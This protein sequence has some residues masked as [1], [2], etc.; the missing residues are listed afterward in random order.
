MVVVLVVVAEGGVVVVV[1][2]EEV[3]VVVVVVVVVA[4]AVLAAVLVVV[5]T[6]APPRLAYPGL[7]SGSRVDHPRLPYSRR[8]GRHCGSSAIRVYWTTWPVHPPQQ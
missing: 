8:L 6:C 1:V 4:V 7:T 3:V 5:A 2:E